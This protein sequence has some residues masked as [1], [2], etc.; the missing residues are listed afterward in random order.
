[1]PKDTKMRIGTVGSVTNI[2]PIYPIRPI[3]KGERLARITEKEKHIQETKDCQTMIFLKPDWLGRY[4][5][6]YV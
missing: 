3:S 1:M 6:M 2:G 4:V 5:D